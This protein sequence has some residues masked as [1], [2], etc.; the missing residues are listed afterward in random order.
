MLELAAHARGLRALHAAFCQL[1]TDTGI[2]AIAAACPHLDSL[3]VNGC[4]NVTDECV[5]WLVH[6]ACMS[7]EL[8]DVSCVTEA[9]CQMVLTPRPS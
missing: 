5:R 7:S 8:C 2:S 6:Y 3:D 1:I 9:T 4:Y